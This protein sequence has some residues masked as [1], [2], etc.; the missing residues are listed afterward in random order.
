MISLLRK[1]WTGVCDVLIVAGLG[2]AL[3]V[4]LVATAFEMLIGAFQKRNKGGTH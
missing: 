3:V 4:L 1:L 2:I